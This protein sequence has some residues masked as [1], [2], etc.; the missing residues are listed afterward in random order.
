MRIQ[1]FLILFLA[2]SSLSLYSQ[3]STGTHRLKVFLDCKSYCDADFIRSEINMVDFLNQRQTADVHV[4][5]FTTETGGGGLAYELILLGQNKF[6]GKKDT[7]RF[8]IAANSTEFARRDLQVKYLKL[9]LVPYLAANNDVDDL[10]IS[11][12]NK[13]AKKDS[14]KNAQPAKDPWN[15]WVFNTGISGYY[16]ADAVYQSSNINGR[17]SANKITEQVKFGFEASA[18]KDRSVFTFADSA[19]NKEK[20]K[21]LNSNYNLNQYYILS[22][23]KHW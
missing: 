13:S 9:G 3:T 5:N 7:L 17:F 4:L 14:T 12:V 15:Y 8:S 16:S 18:G 10:Q 6:A 19:G 2:G 22:L 11:M 21:V 1:F 23:G 20:I